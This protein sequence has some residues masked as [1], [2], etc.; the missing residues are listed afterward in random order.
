[1]PIIDYLELIYCYRN[2]YREGERV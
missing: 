2:C 1:V